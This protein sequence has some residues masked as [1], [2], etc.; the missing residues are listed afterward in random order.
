VT[1]VALRVRIWASEPLQIVRPAC[2]LNRKELSA[3]LQRIGRH[4]PKHQK[5]ATLREKTR[6]SASVMA[7]SISATPIHR[8]V[9]E[10]RNDRQTRNSAGT[11]MNVATTLEPLDQRPLWITNHVV[12]HI[13]AIALSVAA[14]AATHFATRPR[15]D[16]AD[17]T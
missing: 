17:C 11:A 16:E 6:C 4:A 1:H 2:P 8:R 3:A 10:C 14:K 12:V 5:S 7:N 9:E 13:S 15:Q